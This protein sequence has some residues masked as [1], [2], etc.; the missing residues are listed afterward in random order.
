MLTLSA[1][2]AFCPLSVPCLSSAIMRLLCC[3]HR[4][5]YQYGI[6]RIELYN[7]P[8]LDS[9]FTS[10]SGYNVQLW[11]DV[12][13]LRA[14]AIQELFADMNLANGGPGLTPDVHAGAYAKTTYNEGKLGQ[15]AVQAMHTK[16][17]STSPNPAWFNMQTYSYH[18]YGEQSVWPGLLVEIC[19]IIFGAVVAT[20]WYVAQSCQQ[21]SDMSQ[22]LLI[23]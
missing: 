5:L 13:T 18:S 9:K 4:F 8:D 17:G 19:R 11:L 7:E 6:T 23:W 12:Y 14:R 22:C 10:G 1:L 21:L 20:V 15:P 16:F 2:A 3:V